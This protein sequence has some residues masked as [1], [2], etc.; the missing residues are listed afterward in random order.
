M[1]ILM[2]TPMPPQSQAP[3]AI[4]LVLQA[5]LDGLMPWHDITLVTVA[6]G[7]PGEQEAIEHLYAMGLDVWTVQRFQPGSLQRWRRRWQLASTWLRGR[8]PWRTV[9]FWE[10]EVQR[11][12]DRLLAEKV[13]DLILVEDNAMGV[14]N[15]RTKAPLLFTEHEVRRPRAVNWTSLRK[16]DP[17]HWV[18][19][20]ADWARWPRYQRT[21]W[22]RFDRIQTFSKRDADAIGVIAPD[23]ANRVRVNPFGISLPI[24]SASE[25]QEP[26][27]LLFVGNFTHEPN[28]DAA[29]WLG[30]EIMPLIRECYPGVRLT[31]VGIYPP[32]DVRVLACDDIRVTGPVPEIE[33]YFGRAA[34]V[35]APVR[36]GGGM[37]M[38]VLQAMALGKAVVTTSRGADGL[39]ID[40]CQPPLVI[41]EDAQGFASAV[42]QLLAN[43]DARQE[44]GSRARAY[45]TAHF[46][47]QS[48]ASRLE[49]IY[50]EMQAGRRKV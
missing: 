13:F 23:L 36:I 38:K 18:L 37:R 47:A 45:V 14:Y 42:A 30:K 20:E 2:V 11:I 3:G 4:P 29:V 50:A 24:L 31:L 17:L 7:E 5:E 1:K 22:R 49:V 15:Y 43:D 9:W 44:L 28:V 48:Y 21:I 16:T 25:Q 27:S 35:L 34:L 33:P 6:G 8:Y 32:P 10:A 12:L 46:S 19:N 39:A 40:G 26:G 41:S